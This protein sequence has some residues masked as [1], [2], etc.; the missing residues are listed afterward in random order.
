[1]ARRFQEEFYCSGGCGKYFKTF[2]RTDMFGN[3][4]IECPSCGHHHYR[5]IKD[6][7]ITEDRHNDKLGET[8]I[9]HCL[10][11][12]ISSTPWHNDPQ[13]KRQH[14]LALVGR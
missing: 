14:K 5:V 1:M 11:S 4:T 6:G 10:E 7:I 3:Y 2:L 13:F 9:V 12:T 8:E